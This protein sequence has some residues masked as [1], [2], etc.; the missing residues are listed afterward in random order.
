KGNKS[1]EERDSPYSTFVVVGV[2]LVSANS[3]V[4]I[5]QL[6]RSCFSLSSLGSLSQSK[7]LSDSAISLG[8]FS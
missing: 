7:E 3:G 1:F 8:S 6:F 2:L 4:L 5:R